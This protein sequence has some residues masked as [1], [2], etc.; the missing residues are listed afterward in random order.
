M[1]DLQVEN[2]GSI[3]LLRPVSDA[4]TDWINDHID[5]ENAQWFGISV[6]IEHR[7]I[8]DIVD[9]AIHDGLHVN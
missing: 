8:Q 7:Y 4:G 9:G 1:T 5:T 6:V 3:F 2:H